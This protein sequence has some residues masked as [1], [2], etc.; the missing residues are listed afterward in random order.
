M[1]DQMPR[2][3]DH[4]LHEPSGET[5]VVAHV[6]DNGKMVAWCGWP[7]GMARLSE[8]RLTK[9]CSDREH[10]ALVNK[11]ALLPDDDIRAEPARRH[12]RRNNSAH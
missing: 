7:A 6:S 2:A 12:L 5:W 9:Q 10:W 1:A 3:G 11:L 4:V 8:C